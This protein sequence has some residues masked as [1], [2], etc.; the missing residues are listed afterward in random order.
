MPDVIVSRWRIRMP[1]WSGWS[2]SGGNHRP[3]SS[4]TS[5][6]PSSDAIPTRRAASRTRRPFRTTRSARRLSSSVASTNAPSS[7][8][9]S[10]PSAS[11]EEICHG[12][13]RSTGSA[14]R[15]RGGWTGSSPH[16][17]RR[18]APTMNGRAARPERIGTV[19]E[20]R[21]APSARHARPARGFESS[22]ARWPA[23]RYRSS[24]PNGGPREPHRSGRSR[25]RWSPFAARRSPRS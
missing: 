24:A 22:R 6:A 2:E 3:I 14:T 9:G 15:S 8:P 23:R 20:L 18:T 1:A 21:A 13:V 11:G 25:G 4:S 10:K 5:R 17:T 16:A 12:A 7:R 19:T